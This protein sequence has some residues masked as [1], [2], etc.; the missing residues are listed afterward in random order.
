MEWLAAILGG[1]IGAVFG[2]SIGNWWAGRGDRA[3][4][5]VYTDLAAR[6][7]GGDQ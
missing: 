3:L 6:K 1:A 2:L 5:Q 4:N 7:L